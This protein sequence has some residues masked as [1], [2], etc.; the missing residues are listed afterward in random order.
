[1]NDAEAAEALE[2]SD[3]L[4][5]GIEALFANEQMADCVMA[6][7]EVFG[8][9]VARNTSDSSLREQFKAFAEAA[10]LE[11][12]HVKADALSAAR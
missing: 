11:Y 4:V 3:R 1:M 12:Y 5:A 10:M 8:G 6:L 7:A 2:K 9:C